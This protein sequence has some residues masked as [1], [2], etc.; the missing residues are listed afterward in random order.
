MTYVFLG[1]ITLAEGH[2]DEREMSF[3]HFFL[4]CISF[5]SQEFE[6]FFMYLL[7]VFLLLRTV[8]SIHLPFHQLDCSFSV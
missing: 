8:C 4:I 2:F 3:H 7:A 5:M 6:H 1:Y